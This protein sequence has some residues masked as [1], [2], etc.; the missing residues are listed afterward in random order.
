MRK[1]EIFDDLKSFSQHNFLSRES[2]SIFVKSAKVSKKED[3]ERTS[4]AQNDVT[5]VFS[6]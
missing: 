5:Q 4:S 2:I 1:K 6:V 3:G